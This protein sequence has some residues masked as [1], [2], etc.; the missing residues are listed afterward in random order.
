MTTATNCG[1]VAVPD[2]PLVL[3]G[4]INHDRIALAEPGISTARRGRGGGGRAGEKSQD[5]PGGRGYVRRSVGVRTHGRS[6]WPV[7]ESGAPQGVHR[8]CLRAGYPGA[9]GLVEGERV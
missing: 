1:V 2:V 9:D 8:G 3:Y 6:G 4:E 7:C 5:R